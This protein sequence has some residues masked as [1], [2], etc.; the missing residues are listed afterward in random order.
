MIFPK[1]IAEASGGAV[2][3]PPEARLLMY[4][5][6]APQAK[7]GLHGNN[8]RLPPWHS[9]RLNNYFLMKKCK[10]ILYKPMNIWYLLIKAYLILEHSFIENSEIYAF[11]S[12]KT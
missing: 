10:K 4:R 11:N 9:A 3:V 12:Q 7:A 6:V 2:S 5:C 1:R 8:C